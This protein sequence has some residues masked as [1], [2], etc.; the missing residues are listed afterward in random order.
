MND[1]VYLT[2]CDLMLTSISYFLVLLAFYFKAELRKK[3]TN[4]M[5]VSKET[6]RSEEDSISTPQ[7]GEK[8]AA[9]YERSKTYWAQKAMETSQGEGNRGKELRRDGFAVSVFEGE[10]VEQVFFDCSE[11]FK[12]F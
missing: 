6:N 9:F 3:A 11:S 7:P 4:F 2:F 1:E 10:N 5:G 8:M 12:S